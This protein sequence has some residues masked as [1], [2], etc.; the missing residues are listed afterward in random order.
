MKDEG[1]DRLLS[2]KDIEFTFDEGTLKMLMDSCKLED[3][4]EFYKRA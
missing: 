1:K 3:S 4:D 2:Y